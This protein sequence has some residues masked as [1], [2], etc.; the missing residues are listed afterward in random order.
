MNLSQPSFSIIIPA[1]N[2][3]RYI[4]FAL[5]SVFQQTFQDFEVIVVDDGS[6][7]DTYHVLSQINDSRLRI[8]RQENRGVSAARNRG[9]NEAHGK[10]IALL[11]ADDAWVKD[12]L[13]LAYFILKQ[14]PEY[15]WYISQAPR[16]YNIEYDDLK[17][18]NQR[19]N[20]YTA[21][22]WFLEGSNIPMC[23]SGIILK[24]AI[25]DTSFFPEGI[26]MYE[27]NIGFCKFALKHPMV[28]LNE[29]ITAF[30]R[31]WGGSATD[32]YL[33]SSFG[34]SGVEL[35]ALLM[36]QQMAALPSCPKEAKL[37]F[38]YFSYYNWWIRIRS[39]T[40][41]S[42]I[43]EMKRRKPISGKYLTYWLIFFAYLSDI[44][45]RIMGKAVRIKYNHIC[46]RMRRLANQQRV[47]LR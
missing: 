37:F 21:I 35:D 8:I 47:Q 20:N 26:K 25:E 11:D 22:N 39:L 18:P 42:W 38:K 23:S 36:H 14:H 44:F 5:K 12:H 10:Y 27:D 3:S 40:I 29:N 17:V 24:S 16:R 7:D 46:R 33:S 9:I 45:F 15:V 1:Y 43:S 34:K 41:I 4:E 32:R 6:K 2:A 31:I 30:Y 13:E 19:K 28:V